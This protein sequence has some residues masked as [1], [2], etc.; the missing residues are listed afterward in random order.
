MFFYNIM[1]FIEEQRKQ[2][3]EEN[4]TAQAEFFDF[5]ENLSPTTT[6]IYVENALS[7]DIDGEVLK[8]CSFDNITAINFSPGNITS[9][10][11]IPQGVTKIICPENFLVNVPVLPASIVELDLQKNYIRS[12][13]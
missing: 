13:E 8:K 9:L 12:A 11:N 3:L 1:S 5:L 2:V 4:N 7:G 10:T 6:I